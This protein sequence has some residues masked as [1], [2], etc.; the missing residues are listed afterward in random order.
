MI[1]TKSRIRSVSISCSHKG[2]LIYSVARRVPVAGVTASHVTPTK[3]SFKLVAN[4]STNHWVWNNDECIHSAM[5]LTKFPFGHWAYR[6]S[7]N[8]ETNPQ[9][10][11]VLWQFSSNFTDIITVYLFHPSLSGTIFSGLGCLFAGRPINRRFRFYFKPVL[12]RT[13]TINT[14]CHTSVLRYTALV[15]INIMLSSSRCSSNISM[16]L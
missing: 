16:S 1:A 10:Y 6:R 15:L 8:R 2:L 3:T 12:R 4:H 7:I 5:S 13:S 11:C 9:Q 14:S